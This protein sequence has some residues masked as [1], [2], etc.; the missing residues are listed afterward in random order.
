MA[1][2]HEH[3][4]ADERNPSVEFD[5]SD[6][7]ARG[8]LTF[9]IVLGVFA[10]VLNLAVVGMYVGMTKFA[11]K[12]DKE[13]SPLAPKTVTPRAGIL[14]EHGEHQHSEISRAALAERRHRRHDEVSGEGSRSADRPAMAGCARQRASAD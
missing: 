8:I 13:L 12:H 3:E 9:L 14:T 2:N 11:D 6:L 10:V 5:K 1:I 4:S 7:S